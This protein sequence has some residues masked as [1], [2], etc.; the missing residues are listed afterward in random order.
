MRSEAT[1][2]RDG[3]APPGGLS[4][5]L[6]LAFDALP[7]AVWL[8]DPVRDPEG[9]VVDFEV[10]HLNRRAAADVGM[11][12]G[13]VRGR[14][15][16]DVA[17]IARRLGHI[18]RFADVAETGVPVEFEFRHDPPGG[19][20]VWRWVS[21]T[22]HDGAVLVTLRDVTSRVMAEHRR[23]SSEADYRLLAEN[24]TDMIARITPDGRILYMSP[25]CREI[26]GY[27]PDEMVGRP[28]WDFAHPD[29]VAVVMAVRDGGPG[30]APDQRTIT[31]R[32]RRRR[33]GWVWLESTSR[34]V[35]DAD[36]T[37]ME[38]QVAIRDVGER[39]VADAEH[40]ALHRVSEA[41]A[42]GLPADEL[43][44]LV[45]AEMAGVLEADGGRVVRYLGD[46]SAEVLGA[47][48]RDGLP[49]VPAGERRLVD[50]ASAVARVRE[51]GHTAQMEIATRA[52]AVLRFAIAAPV[53]VTGRL[54]GAVAAAY[55]AASDAPAGAAERVERFAKLV[56][57]AVA[58]AEARSRLERQATTDALTGL[59]NHGTFHAALAAAF[60]RAERYGG[61][62]GLVVMDLDHFKALNDTYGHRAGD[63]ALATVGALMREHA[64]RVD[65]V[66]R[67]GGEEFAW[68]MP[69]TTAAGAAEAA[70]RLRRA[71]AEAATPGL[72][73]SLGVAERL[74]G[75]ATARGL[76]DRAD[77]ALFA[78]KRA[79][80]DRVEL[81]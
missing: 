42:A 45:A 13:D 55:I 11:A 54:W 67:V 37:M 52:P 68:L 50:P 71:I 8:I 44:L 28:Y 56:S 63:E 3:T 20:P 46:D 39:A 33:G 34:P 75:D 1:H 19:T 40:A 78:A 74:P 53:R 79:G 36:G 73:A 80:R 81:A 24:A 7:D 5:R 32:G 70:E 30:A 16:G 41:V 66:G 14:R 15:L 47:W 64:R 76:F 38:L 57:L 25:A 58:D 69:D 4:E 51:T 12:A 49:P 65:V 2:S 6:H 17:P 77:A 48:R 21:A 10:A 35:R 27:E 9:R 43:Y 62:L 18:A 22:S 61:P 59:A 72:T 60:E 31:F 26:L 29:D 23:A